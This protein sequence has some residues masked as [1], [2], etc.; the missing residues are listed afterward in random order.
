MFPVFMTLRWLLKLPKY[1]PPPQNQKVN[2]D[3][4][5]KD[6]EQTH[7]LPSKSIFE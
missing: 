3:K 1:F 6:S 4:L 2:S 5:N 7:K